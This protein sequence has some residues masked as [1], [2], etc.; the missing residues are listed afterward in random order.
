M[1]Q[2]KSTDGEIKM[3]KTPGSERY[4]EALYLYTFSR[5][6]T[7]LRDV[8]TGD[9]TA[10]LPLSRSGASAAAGTGAS[11]QCRVRACV[12]VRILLWS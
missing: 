10:Q 5:G 7:A 2:E 1:L 9:S 11:C 12:T 6:L 8:L 4:V 3:D